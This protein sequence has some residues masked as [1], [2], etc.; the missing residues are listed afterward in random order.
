MSVIRDQLTRDNP[1]GLLKGERHGTV[2]HGVGGQLCH[3]ANGYAAIPVTT[4]HVHTKL[5]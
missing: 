4:Y 1:G 5:P 3:G 2:R